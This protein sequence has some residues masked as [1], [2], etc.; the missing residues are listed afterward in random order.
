VVWLDPPSD[1][2]SRA[3]SESPA[4]SRPKTSSRLSRG[5]VVSLVVVI[6]LAAVIRLILLPAQGLRGDLDQFVLW[7]H[8]IA[9]G[10]LPNAYDQNLSFPPVMVYVWAVL[11][12]IQPAFQT[13]TDASDPGIRALMKLP[14]SLADFCLALLVLYALRERLVWGLTAAIAILLHPA[15][16]DVSAWWGQYE[17]IY[18]L[19]ALAAVVFALNGPD[20][21]AAAALALAVMTKPQALPFLVPFAAW[22][23]ARGGLRGFGQATAIGLAVVVLV[24]LPFIPAGGPANYLRNLGEYQNDI[25]SVLSLRAWNVWWILQVVAAG[26]QFASDTTAVLG[27]ITFRH[28]GYVLTGLLELVVF[29]AVLRD[30]R[31]RTLIL[32]LAASTLTA[33][34]FLTT[35]H[36]RYAYG[37]L[38][39]LMLL[40]VERPIRALAIGFGIVFTLN[41]L[42]AVPPT[43]AIAE[44]LPVDGALSL[45]GSVAML[46][47]TVLCLWLLRR[48]GP[49]TITSA[50]IERLPA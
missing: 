18:V 3:A 34:C 19:F 12:A 50:A 5:Q 24:W 42:A 26:G 43:P 30:P 4:A 2:G 33:F 40:L 15:V 17:S 32:G 46:A 21:L 25:F 9:L 38:V 14:A 47:F 37:A 7:V 41:L 39:F 1:T 16:I 44:L 31:P 36:E 49:V 6:G 35:M 29:I 11:A 48:P 22:F 20:G 23:W 45:A 10:G 8:G 13:V 27:P 28:I